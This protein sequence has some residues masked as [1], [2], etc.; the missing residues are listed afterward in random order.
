MIR[1]RAAAAVLVLL[2]L[3][4]A[5]VA[6]AAGQGTTKA[7]KTGIL[8]VTFGT[9]HP[10]ARIA[11]QNVDAKVRAAFPNTPV[12]WAYTSYRIRKKLAD[13][14][15]LIDSPE[16]ALA[17]M[18]D[19]RFTHVAVQSLH[20]IAGFE[21]HELSKNTSHFASM[22]DGITHLQLGYPLLTADADLQQAAEAVMASIPPERTPEEAVVLMGHGTAHPS[23]ALYAALM[24]RL[25]QV[26]PNIFIG[27]VEHY[28]K[29]EEIKNM[30]TRKKITK[31]YLMPLM[32]VAG[33]HAR[34]DLAGDHEGSWQSILEWA[35]IRCVPVL[36]GTAEYDG[37]VEIWVQHLKQAMSRF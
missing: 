1:K 30:L 6:L 26:D 23:N 33:D 21:F 3:Q 19:E 17:K 5:G 22:A 4:L 8:L 36:K 7:P 34:N 32:S 27:T 12:R 35:G 2:F 24:F 31:A 16:V 25:Q 10:E 11:F 14:G 20:T 29:I 13:Q 37:F 28:P 9:S 15:R 18:M